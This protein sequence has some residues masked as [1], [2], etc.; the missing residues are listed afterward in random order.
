MTMKAGDIVKKF[1]KVLIALFALFLVT[2]IVYWFNLDTKLVRAL[3][4][5][6]MKHY[7]SLPRDHRL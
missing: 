5:P 1:L 7:D 4:Q 2:V 3:E 6:L